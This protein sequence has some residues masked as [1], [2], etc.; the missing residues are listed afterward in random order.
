[1]AG[2]LGELLGGTRMLK[3]LLED[4]WLAAKRV[5]VMKESFDYKSLRKVRISSHGRFEHFVKLQTPGGLGVWKNTVFVQSG[6]REVDL[7]INRRNPFLKL[8]KDVERNWLLHIEPPGYIDKL[9]LNEGREME[10]YGKVFTSSPE[11]IEKGGKYIASPPYVHWHLAVNSYT[12]GKD[13][14]VYDYDFLSSCD[15]AKVIEGK[16]NLMSVVNSNINNLPGHKLRAEFIA[17]LCTRGMNFNLFGHNYWSKYPQY[18]GNALSGKWPAFLTSKYVLVIENE[19]SPYY[20]TEKFTD[21][22]LCFCIPIYYGSSRIGEYFPEGS[23]IPLD[24][25][26][27]SAFHDI[28]SI[29][30]SNFYENNLAKLL[31]ARELILTTHNLF[32]FIDQRMSG[33]SI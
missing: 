21:A 9:K 1:M 15:E 13:A 31:K 7:V 24:I 5:D 4:I 11:L 27:P 23:Y 17:D 20:W 10:R 2:A 16:Q 26:R 29:I 3:Y 18:R 25:T 8:N 28:Q 30:A 12:N 19:I 22:I 33:F 14:T 32:N 6:D